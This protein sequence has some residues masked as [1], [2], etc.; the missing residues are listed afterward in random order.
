MRLFN[1]LTKSLLVVLT[2]LAVTD[3]IAAQRKSSPKA[4]VR[5]SALRPII[6][7]TEPKAVVWVDELRRGTTDENGRLNL[8]KIAPGQ[9]Q[10]RVRALGFAEK[11]QTLLPS[12]RGEIRIKL[13]RTT[14]AAELAFQQAELLRENGA[15]AD[16]PKAIELYR[17]ALTARPGFLA[18]HIGLARLLENSDPDE[19]LVEIAATRNIR[20]TL[21]EASTVEGRVY[22]AL[23]DTDNAIKSFRRAIREARGAFVPEAHTGLALA[24]KDSNNLAAAVPE[25]KLAIAQLADT[26]P[27]VYQLLAETCEQMQRNTEAIAAYQKFLELAPNNKQAPAVRSIIKQLKQKEKS[28]ELEL[29]PQ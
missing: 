1:V 20:P 7:I 8:E 12:V 28:D 9:H 14:N 24:Y 4:G 29:L 11:R 15:A 2:A 5:V 23:E 13:V 10:L 27:V 21:S 22:R 3:A 6:I 18:A 17:Q 25:F 26:E 19:A 16:K